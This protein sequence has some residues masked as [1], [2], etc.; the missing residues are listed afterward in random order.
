MRLLPRTLKFSACA[1]PQSD[2][3]STVWRATS[4]AVFEM[5]AVNYARAAQRCRRL[6]QFLAKV[7]LSKCGSQQPKGENM[8]RPLPPLDANELTQVPVKPPSR[9]TAKLSQYRIY[10]VQLEKSF[11]SSLQYPASQF[12]E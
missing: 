12:V 3:K 8:A 9:C 5:S 11:D 1:G 2:N 4:F 10:R 7:R 6:A